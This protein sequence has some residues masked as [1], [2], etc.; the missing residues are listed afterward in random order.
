MA[1]FLANKPRLGAL[2][3][4]RGDISAPQ[5]EQSLE[6]QRISGAPLGDVLIG[7]GWIGWRSLYQAIA[8]QGD[9]PFVDLLQDPPDATLTVAHEAEDY[10]RLGIMPWRHD[11]NGWH[12]AVTRLTLEGEEWI[13]ARYGNAVSFVITS[14]FDIRRTVERLFGDVL[15]EKSRLALWIENPLV[16]ARTTFARHQKRIAAGLAII[17][18]AGILWQPV[19]TALL[20]TAF[21]HLVYA[22][23][24]V[25]KQWVFAAGITNPAEISPLPA[26]IDERTLPIYTILIPMYREASSLPSMLDS[27]RRLDYPT[28]KLDIKLI[29]E[30]D[31]EE[32]LTE[33]R[34]LKPEHCFEIIQ[35]PLGPLRTKPRACNYALRFARG[36]YVTVFDA[37][38]RP[39]PLQLKKAVWAFR[40]APKEVAC[41]QARLNY[42][43]AG[44]NLL[45]RLFSLEYAML[46]HASLRGL[47]R[48]GI[49]IPLGGTSNHISLARLREVG[50]WDPY[51]VTEDAD[52]GVRLAA[53]GLKTRM[54]DSDTMEEAPSKVWPWIKQRS[55]W[56]KGYMQTW[57]VH[58]RSPVRLYRTLGLHGFIGFQFFVGLACFSFLTAPIVWGLSIL[59]ISEITNLHGVSFPHWLL[60]LTAANLLLHVVIHW[61]MALYA[62]MTYH[63]R[64]A[65]S[66]AAALIYPLYLVLH[67]IASYRALWQLFARP[68]FWDKTEHG[69]LVEKS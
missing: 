50:E 54:L 53:A 52:L 38:D 14:P 10:L 5:L 51:N 21:C 27:M 45:T 40:R 28:S 49:P 33:A 15:E 35:V 58:M 43:N 9:L 26:A 57:L 1:E 23:T 22:A 32:T 18:L 69:K 12:M 7:E 29:L 20:F 4:R 46:F 41:L 25:F 34:R 60:W 19:Q 44:D 64:K 30:S 24:M 2:L 48:M 55:R 16:S 65:A 13:R 62:A 59:W 39:D 37:D 36:E 68:H 3:E 42:Y 11:H 61:K 17:T 6:I 63:Q 67:S 47:E 8:E 66:M 31:D 56:I